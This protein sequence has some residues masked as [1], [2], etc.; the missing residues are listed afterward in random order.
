MKN[1]AGIVLNIVPRNWKAMG[2]VA[3]LLSCAI[4]N[5]AS[6]AT[7]AVRDDPLCAKA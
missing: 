3:R 1:D 5:P 7:V 6:A 2:K 4:R